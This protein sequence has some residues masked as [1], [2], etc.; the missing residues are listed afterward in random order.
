MIFVLLKV[1]FPIFIIVGAGYFAVKIGLL[2]SLEI[3]GLLKF[4]QTIA[5]PIFLF[6]SMLSLDLSTIFD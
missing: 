4:T 6:L 3:N 5:I 1:V 2:T